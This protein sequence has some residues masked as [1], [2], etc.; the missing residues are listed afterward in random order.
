MGTE[1]QRMRERSGSVNCNRLESLI[2]VLLR[3]HLPAGKLE[4]IITDQRDAS[5]FLMTNGWLADYSKDIAARLLEGVN[6]PGFSS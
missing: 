5:E 6:L 4:Q 2:Y 3:D 1:N